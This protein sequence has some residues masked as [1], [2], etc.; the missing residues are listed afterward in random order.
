MNP[1]R[2]AAVL[3]YLLVSLHM[4]AAGVKATLVV[5]ET[6][7]L[8]GV[9]FEAWVELENESAETIAV[10][11][12]PYLLA[13]DA[14]GA[15]FEAR[16]AK[17][18]LLLQNDEGIPAFYLE[19]RPQ[20]RRTL[21]MPIR[22]LLRGPFVF[23]DPRIW[24]TGTYTIALRLD[25]WKTL[26]LPP[27]P[28]QTFAGP[29]VTNEVKIVRIATG[30]DA[31]VWTLLQERGGGRWTSEEWT[32]KG[33]V[34]REIVTRYPRSGYTPYAL[35]AGAFNNDAARYLQLLLET[36]DAFP[37][38]PV[39]EVVRWVA[40]FTATSEGKFETAER[41]REKLRASRRP[42]TRQLAFPRGE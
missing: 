1:I 16:S 23:D 21:S 9:P 37:N 25:A 13:T 5:P 22:E 36:A 4:F 30:E 10:G 31:A 41:Q 8:P 7:L 24:S 42:T 18:D 39:T 17:D 27:A 26:M 3:F 33:D 15:P 6:T 2:I 40:G 35:A 32:M 38:S 19:L 11:L 20:E 12:S 29:I 28:P 14:I 34:L